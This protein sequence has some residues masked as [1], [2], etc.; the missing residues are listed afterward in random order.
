M[1]TQDIVNAGFTAIGS[2]ISWANV[3]R[4]YRDKKV[5]GV[6]PVAASFFVLWGLWCLYYYS[7][8][9]QWVSLAAEVNL[10][11]ANGVWVGQ[12]FYYRRRK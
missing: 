11:L 12:M 8:L 6:S 4:L 1:S 7:H 2:V 3:V 5:Q 9:G 10:A